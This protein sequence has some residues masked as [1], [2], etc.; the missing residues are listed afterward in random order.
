MKDESVKLTTSQ[1]IELRWSTAT[2]INN[3]G[4]EIQHLNT[5]F[6]TWKIIGWVDGNYYH[7]RIINSSIKFVM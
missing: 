1:G 3:I 5:T 4:F 2:E 6:D 7:N